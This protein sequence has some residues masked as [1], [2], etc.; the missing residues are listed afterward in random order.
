M[1]DLM[2]TEKLTLNTWW[3]LASPGETFMARPTLNSPTF[4]MTATDSIT[5]PTETEGMPLFV[6]EGLSSEL[7]VLSD[8]YIWLRGNVTIK[9]LK[10]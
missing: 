5:A 1:A 9:Y 6:E 2:Q 8:K 4:Y 7:G 10:G 3:L